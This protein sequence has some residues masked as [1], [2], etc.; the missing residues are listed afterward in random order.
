MKQAVSI[1]IDKELL[2]EI[3]QYCKSQKFEVSLSNFISIAC[4]KYLRNECGIP[5]IYKSEK[6]KRENAKNN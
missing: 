6:W 5:Y 3:L 4:D 2:K 1:T